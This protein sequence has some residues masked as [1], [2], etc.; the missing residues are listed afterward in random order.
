MQHAERDV[1]CGLAGDCP[2]RKKRALS[3]IGNRHSL[4]LVQIKDSSRHSGAPFGFRHGGTA[5]RLARA[6]C[7]VP[8]ERGGAMVEA[9][10]V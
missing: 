3:Q 7:A 10:N 4:F 6:Q 2:H 1:S 5:V 8:F 9:A